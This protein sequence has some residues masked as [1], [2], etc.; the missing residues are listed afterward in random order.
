[1][2]RLEPTLRTRAMRFLSRR[3]HSRAE[4][5]RKLASYVEEG[6]DLTAMLDDLA[7]RGWLS[8]A[9]YA[10]QWVRSKARRFGPVQL[11]HQLR[12]KG[13][14]DEAAAAGIRAAGIDGVSS[15]ESVWRSRFRGPPADD[16]EKARQVRFLQGRGFRLDDVFRF[17]GQLAT[18]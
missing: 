11:A 13:V 16:R 15:I 6:D 2:A 7:A 14:D 4:L 9:R 18:R 3:E 1:M 17:L 8:D 10:E 12:A 5:A